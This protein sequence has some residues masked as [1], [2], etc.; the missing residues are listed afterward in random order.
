[1]PAVEELRAIPGW[2][3]FTDAAEELGVT[4]QGIHSMYHEGKFKRGSVAR[5][6]G[7][8]AV[9]TSEVER[10]KLEREEAAKQRE[11]KQAQAS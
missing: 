9:R 11:E 3:P 7:Q 8:Y 10:V 2:L 6:G 4:K 5:F 1:M